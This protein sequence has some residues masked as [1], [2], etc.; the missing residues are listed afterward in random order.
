MWASRS[1]GEARIAFTASISAGAVARTVGMI[2]SW[3]GGSGAAAPI[4]S[5][6]G[7]GAKS[8]ALTVLIACSAASSAWAPGASQPLICTAVVVRR[9]TARFAGTSLISPF[10]SAPPGWR[11]PSETRTHW[12]LR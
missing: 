6:S 9:R 12:L 10:T 1:A 8:R 11:T 4:T 7:A 5:P 3:P 2:V